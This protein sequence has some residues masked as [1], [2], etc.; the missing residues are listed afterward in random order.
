LARTG[1][2]GAVFDH[3]SESKSEEHVRFVR[4]ETTAR[5]FEEEQED[6][7][8]KKKEEKPK[9]K[10]EK[11]NNQSAV[12]SAFH[13]RGRVGANHQHKNWRLGRRGRR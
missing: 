9:R 12:G 3:L 13:G 4:E 10:E 8:W 1:E 7:I 11:A 5:S 6:S 2:I